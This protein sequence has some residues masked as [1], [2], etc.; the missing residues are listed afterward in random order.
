MET[1]IDVTEQFQK[2]SS[3]VLKAERKGV[4]TLILYR[5]TELSSAAFDGRA[6][7]FQLEYRWH[8]SPESDLNAVQGNEYTYQGYR[9]I[10]GWK[11]KSLFDLFQLF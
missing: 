6:R 8:K 2:W 1:A 4:N 11:K 3:T 9:D 5:C 7:R 10:R